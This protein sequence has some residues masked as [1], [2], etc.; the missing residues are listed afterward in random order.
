MTSSP[1]HAGRDLNQPPFELRSRSSEELG[2]EPAALAPWIERVGPLAI[3]NLETTGLPGD[4]SSEI[5]EV[6]IIRVDAVAPGASPVFETFAGLVRPS[7]TLPRAIQRLTGLRDRDVADAPSLARM[8]SRVERALAGRTIIAHDADFERDFLSRCVARPFADARYLDTQDLLALTHPDTPDLRLET[9][10]QRLL[11]SVEQHRALDDALDTLRILCVI[12]NDALTGAPRYAHA[13]R[14]LDRFSPG[15]PWLALIGGPT[16]AEEIQAPPQYIHIEAS[17]HPPVPFDED[18]ICEA[19][20]DAGRGEIHFPGYRVRKE[21]ID[22]A[23]H[24]VRNLSGGGT[25]L[26]EGGTGVGKSLAYLAAAIPFAAQQRAM[27]IREPV[28]VS[29]RTKLLQDQ[30]LRKDIAAAARMFGHSELR[31]MSMK[32][33]SNYVCKRRLDVVLAEGRELGIFPEERSVHAVLMTSSQTRP[34]GEIAGIPQA[35]FRRHPALRDMLR[36]SVATR[37]EQCSREDCARTPGCPFGARRAA[38]VQADLV[39]ANHDLLLRWPPDYPSFSHVLADEAHELAGVADEVYAQV[40]RPDEVLDRYDELFGAAADPLAESLL[41]GTACRDAAADIAEWRREIALDLT[42]FGRLLGAR[43]GEYGELQLP[44]NAETIH[45]KAAELA[46]ILCQRVEAAARVARRM[47]DEYEGDLESQASA[48]PESPIVRVTG[49]LHD[50]ARRLR[51]AFSGHEDHVASFDG[52]RSPYE[53]W[54]LSIRPVSPAEAFHRGFMENLE[55]FAAVSASLFILGDVFAAMGEL[56]IE[57]RAPKGL[58]TVSVESPFPYLEHMRVVALE[59][60]TDL[61]LDTASALEVVVRELGGRTLGLFTS[62]QRMREVAELLDQRLSGTGIEI[63]VPRLASDDPASLVERFV[64]SRGGAVLLGAR[65][66]WQGLDIP[67]RDLQAVVIEKL[68]FEVPNELRRRREALISE[69]GEDAFGRYTL[70]KMMLHLK[71]MSG[72]LIR[73][74]TDRGLVLIVEGRTDRR[75]FRR[76]AAAFPSGTRIRV[77]RNESLPAIIEELELER[78]GES[79]L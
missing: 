43:A 76:L 67:G 57:E 70:G 24:F 40:V 5:L 73:S 23:R 18:A 54:R 14:A 22:L 31:A 13:R 77:A 59:P 4:R 35:L 51:M 19:L 8:A 66:F 12:A 27:G 61:V 58:A 36:R 1:D 29:T 3:V 65:T 28:I 10:S 30:L 69:R 56:E 44:R 32:G 55:S 25:L 46:E 49:E 6:G 38:L 16:F 64:S 79:Q 9:F 41:P 7:R 15:S 20:A 75:Y 53:R 34:H 45:P 78:G 33:R 50:A 17:E 68:P 71:Q 26:L 21:Q 52:L 62:L 11:G 37:A 42:G 2:I 48:D 72:R 63:L 47:F 60:G 39:V 74:E